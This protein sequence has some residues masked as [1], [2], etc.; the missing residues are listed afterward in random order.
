MS[1]PLAPSV[2]KPLIITLSP[3]IR[4]Q[5]ARFRAAQQAYVACDGHPAHEVFFRQMQ[6]EA[7]VLAIEMEH[8]VRQAEVQGRRRL[9]GKARSKR[10]TRR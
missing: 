8:K 7:L 2:F 3:S 4:S 5:L 6:L 1:D 9:V 10:I